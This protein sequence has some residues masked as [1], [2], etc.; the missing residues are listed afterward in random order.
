VKNS[1]AIDTEV[2]KELQ[3]VDNT[4]DDK[5][6]GISDLFNDDIPEKESK[7]IFEDENIGSDITKLFEEK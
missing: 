3:K 7:D 5:Y 2:A 4:Y 6:E 1:S